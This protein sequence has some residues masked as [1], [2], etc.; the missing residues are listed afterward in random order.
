[1]L[2]SSFFRTSS[3]YFDIICI[4][5]DFWR[6]FVRATGIANVTSTIPRRAGT[7][8]L[9]IESEEDE[10]IFPCMRPCRNVMYSNVFRSFKVRISY[11]AFSSLYEMVLSKYEKSLKYKYLRKVF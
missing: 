2:S 1:M 5:G 10:L 4:I 9:T 8:I 11:P 6:T 7:L 3:L